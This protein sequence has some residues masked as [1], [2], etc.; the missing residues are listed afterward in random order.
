MAISLNGSD[1]TVTQVM[2]VARHGE[3]VAPAPEAV[4]ARRRARAVI[5]DVLTGGE[6]VYGS[7]VRPPSSPR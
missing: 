7:G 5:Q 6:P 1:L 2:A 3:A 4:A